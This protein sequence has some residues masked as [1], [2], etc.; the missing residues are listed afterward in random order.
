MRKIMDNDSVGNI[1]E[2]LS[3]QAHASELL[4]FIYYYTIL[5]FICFSFIILL[6]IFS[7]KSFTSFFSLVT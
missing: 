4:L 7:F 1:E 2:R 6:L 3:S 5:L